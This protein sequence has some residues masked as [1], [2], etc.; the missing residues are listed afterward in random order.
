MH[1]T[2]TKEYY[3]AMKINALTLSVTALMNLSDAVLDGGSWYKNNLRRN[4]TYMTVTSRQKQHTI[5]EGRIMVTRV[6][7]GDFGVCQRCSASYLG[8]VSLSKFAELY[9]YDLWLFCK[10]IL[11]RS[12]VYKQTNK[13][14]T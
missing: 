5:V 3:T 9:S 10:Y 13:I 11:L 14:K 6:H 7:I 2:H 12:I 8:M 4:S 1:Y